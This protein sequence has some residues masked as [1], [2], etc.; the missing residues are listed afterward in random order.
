MTFSNKQSVDFSAISKP[1]WLSTNNNCTAS[2]SKKKQT[3]SNLTKD[4][5]DSNRSSQ[6]SA[7]YYPVSLKSSNKNWSIYSHLKISAPSP[8]F[9]STSGSP[10]LNIG[11]DTSITSY[12]PT[13]Y[14][15]FKI[16]SILPP[17][18]RFSNWAQSSSK[19]SRK[20]WR[21]WDWKLCC[22]I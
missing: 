18:T 19:T 5:P 8:H 1:Y 15:T 3:N 9:S 14:S 11:N 16:N 13:P 20:L 17:G 21:C 12:T 6:N 2:T 10:A 22:T 4:I 7:L